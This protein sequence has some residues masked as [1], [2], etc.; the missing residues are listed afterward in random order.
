MSAIAADDEG[1]CELGGFALVVQRYIHR[2]VLLIRRNE[3]GLVLNVSALP[4]QFLGEQ[5]LS[6]VLWNH[7]NEW[8]RTLL[9]ANRMWASVR[10]CVMTATDVTR[11]AV[12]RNGATTPAMSKISSVRGKIASALECSDCD[13]RASTSRHRNPRRAHS[14][15]KNR[16][17]GPAPTIKTSVSS[18]AILG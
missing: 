15:A 16:P 4:P 1:S 6:H 14:F 11:L 13:E 2:V 9:G 10:P 8:I 17:T 12:S 5:L 3:C 7:G 18:A